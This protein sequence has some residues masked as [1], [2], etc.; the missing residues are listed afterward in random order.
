[1]LNIT[2]HQENA[3]QNHS[4]VSFHT[5][6]NGYRSEDKKITSI[7]ENA[8]KK[9]PLCTADGK[10]NWQSLQKAIWRLLKMLKTE[11]QYDLAIALLGVYLKKHHQFKKIDACQYSSSINLQWPK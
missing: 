7:G 9:E 6:Q 10:V 1:M 3:N 11:L 2:N 8:Q 4:K 5:C